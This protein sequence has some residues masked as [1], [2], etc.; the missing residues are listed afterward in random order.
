[1]TTHIVTREIQIPNLALA[2]DWVQ[3]DDQVQQGAALAVIEFEFEP[4]QRLI[5]RADPDDCQPGYPDQCKVSSIKLVNDV[6][7][8]GDY[9][10]SAVR[11]GTEMAEVLDPHYVESLAEE[12]ADALKDAA[13]PDYWE[14]A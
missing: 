3:F 11:A 10:F 2:T 9:S 1:M 13:T 4:G 5:L 14:A 12:E 7:F 8:H 6:F